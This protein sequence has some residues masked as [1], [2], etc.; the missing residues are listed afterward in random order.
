MIGRRNAAVLPEPVI[1][2]ATTSFPDE[3]TGIVCCCIGVGLI[4]PTS[5][6]AFKRGLIILSY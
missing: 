6:I 2:L 4:Y 1:E 5:L 3:M